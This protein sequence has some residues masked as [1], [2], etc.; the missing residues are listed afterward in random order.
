MGCI[1]EFKMY[2]KVIQ[3]YYFQEFVYLYLVFL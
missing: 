1:Q 2:M 3:A